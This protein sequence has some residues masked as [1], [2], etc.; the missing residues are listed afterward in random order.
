MISNPVSRSHLCIFF[1]APLSTITLQYLDFYLFRSCYLSS[2]FSIFPPSLF[3]PWRTWMHPSYPYLP[4]SF[5]VSYQAVRLPVSFFFSLQSILYFFSPPS[6]ITH[7][8]HPVSL[9]ST[10][11][12]CLF[13]AHLHH[14]SFVICLSFCSIRFTC[15]HLFNFL[16]PL[17]P[18]QCHCES[19]FLGTG[20]L[21]ATSNC[22]LKKRSLYRSRWQQLGCKALLVRAM[23]TTVHP[24]H[25]PRGC[26]KYDPL[27]TWLDSS[28][29]NYRG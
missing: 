18:G 28:L 10:I 3:I 12:Y 7:I 9:I 20:N 13:S 1:L 5:T 2:F 19:G 6:S 29:K 8:H 4:F 25:T 22:T 27:K 11:C 23:L 16:L 24:V 26:V 14:A 15:E 17:N 21:N